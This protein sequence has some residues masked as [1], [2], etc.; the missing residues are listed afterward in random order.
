MEDG[1]KAQEVLD[2]HVELQH[3]FDAAEESFQTNNGLAERDRDYVDGKQWTD[4]EKSTI[5]KRGQAAIV[6]NRIKPKIDFLLGAER[7]RRTDFKGYP[8]TPNHDQDS[9]AATEALR[10]VGDNNDWDIKKSSSFEDSIIEGYGCVEIRFNKKR[11]EVDQNFIQ[12]DRSFYDP[13]ARGKDLANRTYAGQAIW[14]DLE[15]AQDMYP[16]M[17]DEIEGSVHDANTALDERYGD[18]PI[19]RYV[20]PKR[21]RV[22]IIEIWYEKS[23]EVHSATFSKAGILVPETKSPYTDDNK[24]TVD[25][26]E[27][28][29]CYLDREGN[30]YGVVRN[31]IDI[32]DEINKRR[33][34]ALHI[35]SV[36][37]VKIVKG[38]VDDVKV[39]RAELAK[40]DGVVEVNEADG[41][42]IIPT[43][44]MAQGQFSLLQEAKSEIDAVGANAAMTGKDSRQT[45]GRALQSRAQSG[46]VEVAPLFDN[47]RFFQQRVYRKTWWCIQKFWTGERW[48][49]V[50]DNEQ[51]VRFVGLNEAVPNESGFGV[52]IQNEV[53]K[54]DIDII[55]SE[56][57]DTVSIQAEEFANLADMAKSGLPIPPDAIIEASSLRGKDKILKKMRGEFENEEQAA[58]YQEQ[59]DLEKRSAEAD[60]AEK[61]ARA[62][63]LMAKAEERMANIRIKIATLEQKGI[64]GLQEIEKDLD[65][66]EMNNTTSILTKQSGSS[67]N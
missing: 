18:K 40:P 4:E 6:I 21:K 53:S 12:W 31:L 7:E 17:A 60:I 50:T 34:K 5:E 19:S 42:D 2:L 30:P 20:D 41:I 58:A 59:Q 51:N 14:M 15:D 39:A 48:I 16:D 3:K 63:D 64:M 65:I 13:Y 29:V 33:S 11:N 54:M 26:Y 37:Q 67:V 36:R 1:V 43:N 38:S 9:E 35:L 52:T 56:A 32:Q 28:V 44:D 62:R 47:L 10:F 23:S 27:F 25:P 61:E 22:R 24:R 46:Y 55:V 49:R 66:A 57:P 8:R 45:S